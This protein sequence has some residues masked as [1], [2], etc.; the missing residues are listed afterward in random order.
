MKD[1][2]YYEEKIEGLKDAIFEEKQRNSELRIKILTLESRIKY[3]EVD[4]N[5]PNSCC[6]PDCVRSFG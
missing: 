1:A 4:K 3:L 6:C 2:E 5:H